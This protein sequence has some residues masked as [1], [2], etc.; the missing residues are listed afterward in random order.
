MPSIYKNGIEYVTT[1][2]AANISVGLGQNTN[3]NLQ[4]VI[5]NSL[6]N[7]AQIEYSPSLHNYSVGDLLVLNGILYK[8]IDSIVQGDNLILDANIQR[9][10][11]QDV[12]ST[13]VSDN[14]IPS[15]IGMIIM[16]TTLINEA[17]VKDKY[18]SD[19]HWIQHTGYLLRGGSGSQVKAERQV[20]DGGNERIKLNASQCAL[21]SHLHEKG[22][23]AVTG[24]SHGH[25]C[26]RKRTNITV[27]SSGNTHILCHETN[28]PRDAFAASN[29]GH[30]VHT[31]HS[32]T[33]S[34]K[35][36][37]ASIATATDYVNIMPPYK[38]VYIWEGKK[39]VF[40]L[41]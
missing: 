12:S 1:T 9:I 34:G 22:T 30:I 7:F 39:N 18:G 4:R 23:L 19:T 11:I 31:A 25:G 29:Q 38:N 3:L 37:A 15:Y 6:E 13:N 24:G 35:V 41:R 5:Q 10:T 40:V 2:R 20:A 17:A 33:V 14:K 21:P 16:S 36:A 26:Y 8:V 28:T 32:H 27:N